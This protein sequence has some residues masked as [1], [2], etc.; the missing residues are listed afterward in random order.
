VD[1]RIVAATNR[2]LEDMVERGQFRRDLFYRIN[3]VTI[4]VPPL[5]ERKDDIPLLVDHFIGRYAARGGA[6]KVAGIAREALH[7]LQRYDWPGNVRELEHVVE[8]ACTLGQGELIGTGDL[9]EEIVKVAE[10]KSRGSLS[11]RSLKEM[12]VEVIERL[13]REHH[14]DTARVADILGIDRS[15]LYRKIKRYGLDVRRGLAP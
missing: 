11:G 2:P 5:R 6:R 1:V 3:V 15:T 8:R 10:I 14:G 12:E 7:L 9:P 13:M 4:R